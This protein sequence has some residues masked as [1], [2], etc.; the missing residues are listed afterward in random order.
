MR[1]HFAEIDLMNDGDTIYVLDGNDG[2]ASVYTGRGE[3]IWSAWVDGNAI[4]IRILTNDY[5]NIGYGFYADGYETDLIDQGGLT[6][7]AVTLS[8]G[9][10]EAASVEGGSYSLSSVPAGTYTVTASRAHWKFQPASKTVEIPSG[11]AVSEVDF[12]GF[13]P[14]SI[15]GEIREASSRIVPVNIQSPHPYPNN[16]DETWQIDADPNATR[17]RLHFDRISTEPAWDFV[18]VMDGA[19]NIIEIYTAKEIDLWAPWINGNV[20]RIMMTSD[21]ANND[22][23]FKLDKYEIETLGQG[24][25]GARVDLAPDNRSV[26]TSAQGLFSFSEVDLGAH[27]V[28]P[29]LPAWTF[30]PVS[31][32][33]NVPAGMGQYLLFYASAGAL[34]RPSPARWVADDVEV[35]LKDVVVSAVFNGFFYVEDR[36]R[37][38]GLRVVSTASVHEGDAVTITGTMA[39]V[40]GE[41]R[42]EQAVVVALGF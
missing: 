19:D 24:I 39:T 35:T 32:S 25:E 11:G 16:Y 36:D 29:N 21:G 28:A 1:V 4:K 27:T 31:M 6:G 2:V 40:D 12:L 7:A 13:P 30:D 20:A 37:T 23:G 33:V 15:S 22:Y 9:Q 5:G 26:Q 41:R 38:G 18:Y 42:I 14:G 8:P 34:T 3:D 17:M 10:Y